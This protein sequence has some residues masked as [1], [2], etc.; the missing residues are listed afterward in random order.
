MAKISFKNMEDNK[1]GG[2]GALKIKIL[3]QGQMVVL[4]LLTGTPITLLCVKCTSLLGMILSY[5][6]YQMLTF[7]QV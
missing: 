1:V 5:I 6:Q 4:Q 2:L 3:R 7:P